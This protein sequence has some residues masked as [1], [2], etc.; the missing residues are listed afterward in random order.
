MVKSKLSIKHRITSKLLYMLKSNSCH[1]DIAGPT[2][3]SG[4]KP[5]MVP[6]RPQPNC[7]LFPPKNVDLGWRRQFGPGCGFSNPGV[8]CFVNA[9]LQVFFFTCVCLVLSQNLPINTWYYYFYFL[10]LPSRR[11]SMYHLLWN[12]C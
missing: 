1:Y 4:S 10:L 7:I 3:P 2:V 8:T 9:T 11:F 12:G 5:E 6:N